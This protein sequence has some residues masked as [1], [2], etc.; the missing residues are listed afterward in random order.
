MMLIIL[1]LYFQKTQ[2]EDTEKQRV[3]NFIMDIFLESKIVSF[4]LNLMCLYNIVVKFHI[5]KG[6]FL[7]S[8][9]YLPLVMREIR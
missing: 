1:S 5:F 9:F 3:F 6:G 4:F 7:A 2:F 8:D